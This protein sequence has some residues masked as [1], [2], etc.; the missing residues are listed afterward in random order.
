[1]VVSSITTSLIHLS[2]YC[3]RSICNTNIRSRVLKRRFQITAIVQRSFHCRSVNFTLLLHRTFDELHI[4]NYNWSRDTNVVHSVTFYTMNDTYNEQMIIDA[5]EMGSYETYRRYTVTDHTRI[6][7]LWIR[8]WQTRCF[9]AG[10]SLIFTS[11]GR[12]P[13]L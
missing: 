4:Y 11:L 1:M 12:D 10:F 13:S 9:L 3:S 8:I 7:I 6:H 2:I 5:F